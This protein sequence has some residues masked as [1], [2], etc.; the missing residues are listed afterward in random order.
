MPKS[1]LTGDAGELYVAYMLS[2]FGYIA[3]LV[4]D[5]APVVDIL[6]TNGDASQTIGIQVKTTQNAVRTRGRSP[7]KVPHEVQFP[8]G[9]KA[10]EKSSPDLFFCFV[11][12]RGDDDQTRPDVYVIPGAAIIDHYSG[13]DIRQ[14]SYF[15]FHWPIEKVAPYKN[16]WTPIKKALGTPFGA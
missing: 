2:R 6:A 11:D 10:V 8:L 9:H 1:K 12:L 5:G 16:D 4:R 3:A 14:H 7:N 13:M 15:R